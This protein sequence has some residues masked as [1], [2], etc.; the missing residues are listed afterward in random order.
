MKTSQPM[1]IVVDDELGLLQSLVPLRDL[2]IIELGSG[3]AELARRLVA[4]CPGCKLA[5]LEVDERQHAKSLEQPL[6]GL[7]FVRAGAQEIPYESCSFDL[8]LMLKSLHHVPVSQM[9]EALDEVRRVLKPGGF[10]YVSEP[11]FAGDL[12]EVI[13]LFHDEQSVRRAACLAIRRAVESRAW[14]G[15]SETSFDMPV[16]FADFADFE[17]RVVNVTFA[18]HRL[19]VATH[20]RVR[21]QFEKHM[22][23]DGARF[24]RPMRANLLR[25][26][27]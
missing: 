19:D 20:E 15:V 6:A 3:K 17:Q 10:L 8:A 12:N 21:R 13:R 7:S 9:D 1:S 4:T 14:E 16:V 25:K 2:E 24:L 22:D 5:A 27:R 23:A 11:V 26:R 18:D